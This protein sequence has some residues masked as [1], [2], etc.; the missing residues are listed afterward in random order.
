MNALNWEDIPLGPDG[1]SVYAAD[2]HFDAVARDELVELYED[3][4]PRLEAK[5]DHLLMTTLREMGETARD[6]SET[7]VTEAVRP[8]TISPTSWE[9]SRDDLPHDQRLW[10][11]SRA[12]SRRR[13]VSSLEA[14]R[15]ITSARRVRRVRDRELRRSGAAHHGLADHVAESSPFQEWLAKNGTDLKFDDQGEPRR[16]RID[17]ILSRLKAD[18]FEN[19]RTIA[20]EALKKWS[21]SG[22]D[23]TALCGVE[24]T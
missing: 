9:A 4:T 18:S 7:V 23:P 8:S 1:S 11:D 15:G 6:V 19:V 5:T 14:P 20:S 10:R 2:D 12:G 17:T 16:M 13:V 3:P 21:R 22:N 24:L